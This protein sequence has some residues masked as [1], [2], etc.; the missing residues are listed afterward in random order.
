MTL[1]STVLPFISWSLTVARSPV[2]T[3]AANASGTLTP[4]RHD[5]G[6][7]DDEQRGFVGPG[8]SQVAGVDVALGDDAVEGRIRSWCR[9]GA[10]RAVPTSALATSMAAAAATTSEWDE[11]SAAWLWVTATSAVLIW[12]AISSQAASAERSLLR[13]SSSRL[14]VAPARHE[15]L[16]AVK[17]GLPA[18]EVG[19]RPFSCRPGRRRALA[20]APST[21]ASATLT[22][23]VACLCLATACSD[24]GLLL[25]EFGVQLGD[26]Q[27]REDLALLDRGADVDR[28]VLDVAG[29]LG[30]DR[31]GLERLELAG[32]A[33]AAADGV[34]LGVDDLD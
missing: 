19:R 12:A 33:D 30:V 20:S 4:D 22:A 17:L 5:V 6:A 26:R 2:L 13:V 34:P 29:N 9:R 28:P 25:L 7:G 21:L 3:S 18:G 31:R 14:P 1:P 15:F 16:D 8:L 10:P 11:S 32:L 24:R 27:F 23:A